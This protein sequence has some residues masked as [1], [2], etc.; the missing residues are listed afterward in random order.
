ML[1]AAVSSGWG[2]MPNARSPRANM[3][4]GQYSAVASRRAPGGSS[5]TWS[6][7][8]AMSSNRGTGGVHPRLGRRRPRRSARPPPNRRRPARPGR[9]SPGPAAGGRSRC[10]RTAARR[11]RASRTNACVSAIHGSSSVTE[12]RPGD[13]IQP[14]HSSTDVG[15]VAEVGVVGDQLD[16][17][18]AEQ[19]VEQR[20]VVAADVERVRVDVSAQ[21]QTDPS[22]DAGALIGTWTATCPWRPWPSGATRPRWRE[23]GQ[24]ALA[25]PVRLLEVRVPGEDELL[26]AELGVLGDAVGDLVVAPD[27]RGAGAAAHEADAGPDV[28]VQLERARVARIAAVAQRGHPA[29]SLRL[30]GGEVPAGGGDRLGVHAGEEGRGGRPGLVGGR[31]GDDVEPDPEAQRP[32]VGGRLVPHPVDPLGD[33]RRRLAP[34]EVHVDAGGGDLLGGRRRAAEV[35]RRAPGPAR[36]RVVAPSTR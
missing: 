23:A 5:T 33:H 27:Q 16:A 11:R 22:R 19:V 7:W 36:S 17:V 24:H 21:E 32:A 34:G 25:A 3:A 18:P 14:S 4:F 9:P 1:W 30:G 28:R 29:L 13:V 8:L 6:S 10:R 20:R 31:S 26:E 2:W 15:Q 35:D 12:G